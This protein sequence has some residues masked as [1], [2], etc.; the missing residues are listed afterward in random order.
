MPMVGNW[1]IILNS[2][3]LVEELSKVP[4]ETMSLHEYMSQVTV[5]FTIKDTRLTRAIQALAAEYT[6]SSGTYPF[7]DI[8]TF[9]HR[10]IQGP[11]TKNIG[12]IVPDVVDV[13]AAAFEENIPGNSETGESAA[14]VSGRKTEHPM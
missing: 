13:V 2:P 1:H 12:L 3:D 7:I 5:L 9:T 10:V 4:E 14:D 6:F 8:A 11:I